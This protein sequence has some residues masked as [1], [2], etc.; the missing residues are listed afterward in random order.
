[1]KIVLHKDALYHKEL[2]WLG[3]LSRNSSIKHGSS[4]FLHGSNTKQNFH[5]QNY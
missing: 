1:M 4:F 3:T 2:Q 5:D